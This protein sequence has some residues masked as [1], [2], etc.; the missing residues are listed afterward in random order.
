M[1]QYLLLILLLLYLKIDNMGVK[2]AGPPPSSEQSEWPL[3]SV[4][5]SAHPDVH[6]KDYEAGAPLPLGQLVEFETEL[7]VGKMICRLKPIPIIN[8]AGD[9]EQAN[10]AVKSHDEYFKNK[11]RLYQFVIQ[12]QF[13]KE[14]PLSD[15]AIG[16]IHERPF[17]GVPKG[18]LMRLYQKFM[19]KISPG[20]VM[21]MT[22][23]TPTILTAFGSAQI[24]R[25][26]LPGDEPDLTQSV[27][28]NNLQDN[29][30]LLFGNPTKGNDKS[31]PMKGIDT[32]PTKRKTY[33]SK[34]KH[35]AKYITCPDHVYTVE[36]YDHTMCFGSY[37]H[38]VMGMKIDMVKTMNAQPLSF[39]IFTKHD[40][41]VVSE[42]HVWHERLL[43]EMKAEVE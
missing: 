12:G 24:M 25:A 35:A 29:T 34:P 7:F 5:F 33:L 32:S 1:S 40:Q 14:I 3:G 26:D 6:T 4:Y 42:F 2:G 36:V 17:L 11:K 10:P 28:L 43:K 23:E 31:L 15:I 18:T 37:Y 9:G 8:D 38:Y 39:G 30:K 19:E 21:D 16:D 41:A 20:L 13:R 27:V 22:S